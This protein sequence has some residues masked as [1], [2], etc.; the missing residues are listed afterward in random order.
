M[1][2]ITATVYDELGDPDP[3][4]TVHFSANGASGC[5][6]DAAGTCGAQHET[7][8]TNAAGQAITHFRP[9]AV[10]Q[11][12][13]SAWTD[14][15]L[16]DVASFDAVGGG[17]YDLSL[18][19]RP[20]SIGETVSTYELKARV[21]QQSGLPPDPPYP[22]MFSTTVGELSD[23]SETLPWQNP[24]TIECTDWD[25]W[26]YSHL[27][28]TA[29]GD[30]YVTFEYDNESVT[31][32][33]R[34][35][36]GPIPA[37]PIA[38]SLSGA[39]TASTQALDAGG[40]TLVAYC[41]ENNRAYV[42]VFS[43]ETWALTK[44]ITTTIQSRT[45]GFAVDEGGH[46]S[47]ETAKGAFIN[48][49]TD[50]VIDG[51]DNVSGDAAAISADGM[52]GAAKGVGASEV[53]I[54]RNNG[55]LVASIPV[56]V[57]GTPRALSFS[58]D[59]SRLAISYRNPDNDPRLEI[60]RTSNWSHVATISGQ[61]DGKIPTDATWSP[62]SQFVAWSD[63]K[64]S[65]RVRL[66]TRD[67][68]HVS[69][70]TSTIGDIIEMDWAPSGAPLAG[71]ALY[72]DGGVA[73]HDPATG[74]PLYELEG[75]PGASSTLNRA[76]MAWGCEGRALIIRSNPVLVFTPYDSQAPGIAIHE[77]PDGTQTAQP[78]I[79]V[80]GFASDDI[81]V[82]AGSGEYR[83]NGGTWTAC[84]IAPDGAFSFA[85]ALESGLNTVEVCAED[86]LG[87]RGCSSVHVT[88]VTDTIPPVISNI[89]F[90]PFEFE[91]GATV[92]VTAHIQDD[93]SGVDPATALAEI[94]SLGR[95][96]VAS[97]PLYDDG[98]HGDGG[99]G[100][101]VSGSSWNTVGI[102]EGDYQLRVSA[103]DNEGNGA[104]VTFGQWLFAYDYPVIS[105]VAHTPSEPTN[106]DD[107]PVTATVTDSTGL[108][109]VLLRYKANGAGSWTTLTMVSRVNAT[110]SADIPALVDGGSVEYYVQATDVYLNTASSETSSYTVTVIVD[111]NGDF[112]PDDENLANCDGSP[113]CS[114]C[115][116]NG[117]PD[118]CDI[119]DCG[120]ADA[121][122]QDCNANG[123][124]DACDVAPVWN[125]VAAV[126]RAPE[127]NGQAGAEFG[128][129]VVIA[130]DVAVVGARYEDDS[131]NGTNSGAVYVSRRAGESWGP[132]T[133]LVPDDGQPGDNFG[134]AVALDGNVLVIGAPGVDEVED[135]AGGAYVYRY[136][137]GG[138]IEGPRLL[139]FG[140][141]TS[142]SDR[143]GRSV[144][145]HGDLIVVGAPRDNQSGPH[146]GAAYVFRR[147]EGNWEEQDKLLGEAGDS[148]GASVAV[149]GEPGHE[150]IAVGARY[151][152]ALTGCVYTFRESAGHWQP[153]AEL[154]ALDGMP[155]DE[156]GRSISMDGDTLVVGAWCD[157]DGG[158][159][160]G[161]AYVYRPNGNTW[162][163]EAKL[164]PPGAPTSQRF[165]FCVSVSGDTIAV[166]EDSSSTAHVFRRAGTT[167]VFARTLVPS[168][169]C[170]GDG[171]GW[172]SVC[173]DDILLG[174]RKDPYYGAQA[175]AAYLYEHGPGASADCNANGVPDDC[176]WV[177]CNNNGMLDACDIAGG[178][179]QDADGNG[180]P[181]ECEG[182]TRGDLNCDGQ[183]N[184]F[185]IDPFVLALVSVQNGVPEEY[186]DAYPDCDI[187]L[188]DID[189]DGS[190]TLFDV[191]PFVEL[192]TSK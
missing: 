112:I 131:N 91:A 75:E 30:A 6:A 140:D 93:W 48:L 27:R 7:A 106:V 32:L 142:P 183:L 16:S 177:D 141:L 135:N 82:D 92:Q 168:G 164:I 46:W 70:F 115:D 31:I 167:W 169:A 17:N 39:H 102:D 21:L 96:V 113:W 172:I 192:L 49:L 42:D 54:L 189:A 15:G 170:S 72:G 35:H 159:R 134:D 153:E 152:N 123:V 181:D 40:N 45:E 36:V 33:T 87:Q 143:F 34:L 179:S 190:V 20:V 124:P 133:R 52:W 14:G 129:T 105:D 74:A 163:Q 187:M 182:L 53:F 37:V 158:S 68:G 44:T 24:L 60:Y 110:W 83:I 66:I 100:D 104:S 89:T 116:G 38:F 147:I 62:D 67:G 127:A 97:V 57:A 58:P 128:S 43:T 86:Y 61:Q 165:G 118:E 103:A 126:L 69:S 2:T 148:L 47:F 3:G 136:S 178:T 156:F 71:L 146:A 63:D 78:S 81:R 132:P 77:P 175:G 18:S 95:S 145:V 161:S 117:I 26:S 84:S 173:G 166:A 139:P 56:N 88:R 119:A 28:T 55:S 144:A 64:N 29:A 85:A 155:G 19:I 162:E 79:V 80:S 22:V 191:D 51:P 186:Y 11:V 99:A 10:G 41:F 8:V 65:S 1:S 125:E 109:S 120:P 114:D 9:T 157:G 50:T 23:R 98:V 122:C 101:G 174:V 185:D 107:V 90:A 121:S 4:T 151:H 138:W 188:A 171:F 137:D 25:G 176:E 154:T 76:S 150:C 94:L 180:I 111:C 59:S 130:G 108:S 5:F 149:T 160:S 12:H 184:L 73:V 13:I